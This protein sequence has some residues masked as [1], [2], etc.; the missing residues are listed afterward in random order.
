MKLKNNSTK[1]KVAFD[2]FYTQMVWSLWYIPVVLVIYLVRNFIPNADIENFNLASA[3]FQPSKIYML[4]IGIITSF[5]FLSHYVKNGIT[6]KDYF[7]GSA[8][9]AASVAISIIVLSIIPNEVFR[10]F[11]WSTSITDI[12]LNGTSIWVYPI[13]LSLI[14]VSYYVAG[15]II[16]VS[17][18][19]F[20]GVG[21]LFIPL[22]ILIICLTDLLWGLPITGPA[23]FLNISLPE[24]SPLLS[25]VSTFVLI[26]LGLWIIRMI[27]KEITID[28]E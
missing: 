14:L 26:G 21:A 25:M 19:K 1:F 18:Y 7:I 27:T 3:I 22:A 2:L 6:R 11:G 28:P 16:A 4:V 15:W 10:L 8:I 5:A 23:A 17:F 9:A 20:G 24:T 13:A 12:G